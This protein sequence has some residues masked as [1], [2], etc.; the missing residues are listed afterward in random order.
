MQVLRE[1]DQVY[2]HSIIHIDL[3][4][5]PPGGDVNLLCRDGKII[6]PRFFQ[7]LA[8]NSI[9]RQGGVGGPAGFTIQKILELVVLEKRWNEL[10]AEINESQ[11]N[12][13]AKKW[14]EIFHNAVRA[15]SKDRRCACGAIEISRPQLTPRYRREFT[16]YAADSSIMALACRAVKH[17]NF[18]FGNLFANSD[19]EGDPD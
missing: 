13:D 7:H 3:D 2:M 8:A 19:A 1:K 5:K 11:Q 17:F 14:L 9:F 16:C 12:R 18:T 10:N 15:Q 4:L 6:A